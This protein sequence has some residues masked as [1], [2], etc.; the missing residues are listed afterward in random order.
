MKTVRLL[1]LSFFLADLGF[2]AEVAAPL[3]AVAA[4]A[5]PTTAAPSTAAATPAAPGAA[6]AETTTKPAA[7]TG[8]TA[9]A[10]TAAAVAAKAA[11]VVP[12]SPRFQQVRTR[13]DAL[14]QYR[15]AKPAPIDPSHN[16]FRPAGVFIP[17]IV[18]GDTR[19]AAPVTPEVQQVTD[20]ALLQQTVATLK[21][22]GRFEVG[23]RDLRM[24]NS[25]LYKENDVVQVP[26]QAGQTVYLRVKAVT[27]KSL[28][29]S[30]NQAEMTI[31]F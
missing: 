8:T 1:A 6:T 28:T 31:S 16:P 15:N 13:V 29:L 17:T 14:F 26:G 3:P 2:A 19:N 5:T 21:I 22:G 18:V 7:A 11:V 20:L 24:I 30:L 25:R 23:G 27:P 9:T 4:P 12:L 10:P